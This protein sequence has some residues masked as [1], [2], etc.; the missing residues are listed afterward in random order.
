MLNQTDKNILFLLDTNCR[1]SAKQI[2]KR[3]NMKKE[4]VA[5][6]VKQLETKGYI[7]QY[8]CAIDFT[9]L[10][11]TLCRYY[12][13]LQK[14]TEEDE[15][16]MIQF[17]SQNDNV[18]TVFKVR[19]DWDIACGFCV[20]THQEFREALLAFKEKYQEFIY[21][22]EI[23]T[24]THFKEFYKNY[25]VDRELW[26]PKELVIGGKHNET[27]DETDTKILSML[28]KDAKSSLLKIAEKTNLTSAAVKY[29]IKEL[30]RKQVILGFKI[31]INFGDSGINYY[32]IDMNLTD[33]KQLPRFQRYIREHPNVVY[34]DITVGGSDF[35]FDIE[36]KGDNEFENFI[37]EMK[38]QFPR[39]IK[40]ITS[41]KNLKIYKFNYFP[42]QM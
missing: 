14:T 35:E 15:N 3:L 6:R 13:K 38:K 41:Y 24:F 28:A 34:E 5:Y 22:E 32:K 39:G 10:G 17:L 27:I 30:E 23:T 19:G 31:L 11:Y 25:L 18:F 2:A 16:S 21:D 4:T 9:K 7:Q 12:V 42:V 40:N 37:K 8:Y 1:Q 33:I 29:R 20:R 36:V 26:T